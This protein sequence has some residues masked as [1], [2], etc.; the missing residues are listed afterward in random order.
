MRNDAKSQWSDAELIRRYLDSG[1]QSAFEVLDNRYR[2][3]VLAYVT[4]RVKDLLDAEEIVQDT[5]V[6]AHK[7][8][9]RLREAEKLLNWL[10]SIADQQIKIRHRKNRTLPKF[11]PIS[12]VSEQTLHDIAGTEEQV[13]KQRARDDARWKHLL[14]LANDLPKRQRE[15]LCL[16]LQE[17]TYEEIADQLKTSVSAVKDLLYRAR[18]RLEAQIAEAGWPDEDLEE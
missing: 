14:R 1:D 13:A 6:E 11:E 12:S 2:A 4:K 7:Q 17:F 16:Q 15:A 10:F 18:K 8:L 5:F 3:R 9:K